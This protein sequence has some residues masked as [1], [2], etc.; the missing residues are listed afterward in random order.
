M[1][2]LESSIWLASGL[3][4]KCSHYFKVGKSSDGKNCKKKN[5]GK[6]ALQLT[7]PLLVCAQSSIIVNGSLLVVATLKRLDLPGVYRLA[8]A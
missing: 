6:Y 7:A 5:Y 4:L 3:N 1:E 8:E 2:I